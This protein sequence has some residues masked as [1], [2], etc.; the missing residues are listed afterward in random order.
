MAPFPNPAG[1]PEEWATDELPA[2]RPAPPAPRRIRASSSA[3][4]LLLTF[5]LGVG[6]AAS[7]L[8]PGITG[9]PFDPWA[10]STSLGTN[11]STAPLPLNS[12]NPQGT[13]D[14]NGSRL[15]EPN[16]NSTVPPG[17]HEN[18]TT[19]SSN[20]ST[21][22]GSNNS[23]GGCPPNCHSTPGKGN[24]SSNSTNGTRATP[25]RPPKKV[26][27]DHLPWFPWQPQL[28][29]AI[30]AF[31][32]I[33]SLLALV[34]LDSVRPPP[35][36]PADPWQSERRPSRP[37]GS[38]EDP[39]A[40]VGS[41]ARALEAALGSSSPLPKE[42]LRAYIFAL[43]GALLQA[44]APALGEL[45]PRTPREVLWLAVRYLGV[46]A[47]SAGWLTQLFE[48]A[49][50]SSHPIRPEAIA[51]ARAALQKLLHELRWFAER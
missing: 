44:V 36:A 18:S 16:N 39:R 43:Y 32:A 9:L 15:P 11:N 23:T 8:A 25:V 35:P 5:T 48:E 37:T 1:D 45:G 27:V 47:E 12:S 26:A 4:V 22:P 13:H 51:P 30:S 40:A 33:G 24:T 14:P 34:T 21:A 49:R 17:G 31:T 29:L 28:L 6:V 7:Y 3:L 50:Y 38:A 41:A 46:S 42:E 19:Q 10:P 20:N 2:H